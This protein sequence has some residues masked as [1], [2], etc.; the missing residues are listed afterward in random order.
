RKHRCMIAFS[1]L[2]E[3]EFPQLYKSALDVLW[4]WIL[5]RTFRCEREAENPAAQLMSF[6]GCWR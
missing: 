6:A 3:V 4:P 1:S 2:D 5:S